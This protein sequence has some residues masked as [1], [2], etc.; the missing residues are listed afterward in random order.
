MRALY[1]IRHGQAGTR[2]DYDALSKIGRRQARLLG[3]YLAGQGLRFARVCSGSLIRQRDTAAEVRAAFEAAAEPFPAIAVEPGW[4]EFDLA[5]IYRVVAPQMC[6]GDPVFQRDYEDLLRRGREE[7]SQVHR[8]WTPVDSALFH[9]WIDGRYPFDGESWSAFTARIRRTLEALCHSAP[10]GPVAVFTSA[11]PIAIS[12]GA[13]LGVDGPKLLQLTGA[14]LNSSLTIFHLVDGVP[15]LFS[16]NGVP[17]LAEESLRT[18][19]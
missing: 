5:G 3:E 7:A 8:E 4:D 19:R 10:D 16:F 13:V 18:F 15:R 6:A 12:T 11:T 1:F 2:A 17:H 14:L 9:A